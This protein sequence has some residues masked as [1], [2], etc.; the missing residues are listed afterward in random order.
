MMHQQRVSCSE[1]CV[2]KR[3]V[4]E[5]HQSTLLAFFLMLCAQTH[6]NAKVSKLFQKSGTFLLRH[7]AY[8]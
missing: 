2:I 4:G 8:D 5:W 7:A 3:A 1:L 6:Q